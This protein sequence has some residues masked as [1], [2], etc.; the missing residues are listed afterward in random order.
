M[1]FQ[2][3]NPQIG[4]QPVQFGP[5]AATSEITLSTAAT[6]GSAWDVDGVPRIAL[7]SVSFGT[8]PADCQLRLELSFDGTGFSEFATYSKAQYENKV[9]VADIKAKK[10][11]LV[12]VPG[13]LAAGANGLNIT[14]LI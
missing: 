2:F 11:R 10:M 7:R 9:I 1:P 12:L 4:A 6:F 3:T 14:A 5:Y 8:I 13:S